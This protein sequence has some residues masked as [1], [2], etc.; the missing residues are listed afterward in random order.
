MGPSNIVAFASIS[1]VYPAPLAAWGAFV[2]GGP[3][4]GGSGV[5]EGPLGGHY[6]SLGGGGVLWGR[7]GTRVGGTRRRRAHW[8]REGG[9]GGPCWSSLPI[10]PHIVPSHLVKFTTHMLV[11][12]EATPGHW[13]RAPRS[14]SLPASACLCL[15]LLHSAALLLLLCHLVL[16]LPPPVLC[17]ATPLQSS[18]VEE[19]QLGKSVL[20][21]SLVQA[22]T[23]LST[24]IGHD[25]DL[26]PL[27]FL[28]WM[29]S[30]NTALLNA[31]H[32]RGI[33]GKK[34]R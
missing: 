5:L 18:G 8:G 1:S 16:V 7:R 31:S 9:G 23:R 34:H 2:C 30:N 11:P 6:Q 24:D 28:F 21:A 20:A 22:A 10:P 26:W 19:A 14:H 3:Q 33:I 12:T 27:T 15:A 4:G 25:I 29:H 13:R 32:S 17:R